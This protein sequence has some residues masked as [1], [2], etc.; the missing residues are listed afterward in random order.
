MIT[1]N[2]MRTTIFS[3][4]LTAALALNGCSAARS[5]GAYTAGDAG[6]YTHAE[7][8]MQA[9]TYPHQNPQDMFFADYGVNGFVDTAQDHLSTFAVDVDTGAY[10][11]ARSYVSDDLLPPAEAVRVEEFVN[12]F[13]YGYPN[14]PAAETFEI[15]MD[16]APSPFFSASNRRILRV[17]IQGYAIPEAERK[18]VALTFVVDVSGSMDMENRLGLVKRSLSIM[19]EQLR[20]TD[21]VAIVEYGSRA[22][23]VLPMT[24]VD[25][26]DRILEA[27]RKLRSNGSTNAEEGLRLGYK[28]AFGNFSPDAINRV[29]LASDGVANVGR[30]GPDAIMQ[31]IEQY[32]AQGITMTSVGV[33]MG[34]YNDVLM[35]QLA[36]SGDGFYAYV[37]T[38]DE[39]RKLF[40][41]D[42][43]STLQTIAMDAK[44]QVDF[45]P[46]TVSSYRLVGYE[47]R[48]VADDDFRND[49]VDAGEIGA[50]HSVTA[51]YELEIDPLA[52][53]DA[54]LASV[55]L[56]WQQVEGGEIVELNR[57]MPAGAVD[58]AFDDA[59]ANFQLAV[60]VAE[61]AEILR[62]S[63]WAS[64]TLEEL[65]LE[66]T[67]IH[68][69]IE[70]E[71][72]ADSDVTELVDLIWAAAEIA[73]HTSY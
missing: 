51:L 44:V 14:P 15:V 26:A 31:V 38:L 55:T 7:L 28:H 16:A 50:G 65:L 68:D 56:R 62:Q 49:E 48:D 22:R 20:P 13:D 60:V 64:A 2:A 43:T 69:R 11:V 30:T 52:A 29:I 18:D 9:P 67:R 45:N 27:I 71:S 10:S 37:D 34:N 59:D 53:A 6:S 25:Q 33:G 36:D 66:A 47:N 8:A 54:T 41:Q 61:Y 46:A 58:A 4:L 3:S 17:G 12:Y 19:V 32:A 63:E 21:T 39:A 5:P 42:L 40:V 70:A 57:S 73:A 1:K 24:P 72:G 35:E 23:L